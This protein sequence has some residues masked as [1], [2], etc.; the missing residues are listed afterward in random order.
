[1]R[2]PDILIGAEAIAKEFG[3]KPR[4]V[5]RLRES[6]QAPIKRTPGL[7][8]TA[9]KSLLQAYLSGQHT[10]DYIQPEER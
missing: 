2:N 8:I 9:S 4:Q 6:G 7:G 10:Q 3:M 5:Y 1:M